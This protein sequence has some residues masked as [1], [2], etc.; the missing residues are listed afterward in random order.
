MVVVGVRWAMGENVLF[1]SRGA[2]QHRFRIPN[3]SNSGFASDTGKFA[4][5]KPASC[6]LGWV[7]G[8]CEGLQYA[9]GEFFFAVVD[10]CNALAWLV[11]VFN[12][13]VF[14]I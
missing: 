12:L 4:S 11:E 8:C 7:N 3:G 2:F 1:Y 5:V 6:T 10:Q 9:K 13:F 14:A